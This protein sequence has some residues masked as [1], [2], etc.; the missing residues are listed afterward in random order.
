VIFPFDNQSNVRVL[1]TVY[2]FLEL[3]FDY[4]QTMS[5]SH[6]LKSANRLG[7]SILQNQQG[8]I[9]SPA[10][11]RAMHHR[12]IGNKGSSPS[13]WLPRLLRGGPQ[14]VFLSKF[15]FLMGKPQF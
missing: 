2:L 5:L 3:G 13:S 6:L 10:S 14:Q 4:K 1:I 8:R 9:S 7:L 12:I 15:Y 11:Y